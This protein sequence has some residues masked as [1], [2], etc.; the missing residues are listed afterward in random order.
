MNIYSIW[1][2]REHLLIWGKNGIQKILLLP[3]TGS[4]ELD[5]GVLARLNL[6]TRELKNLEKLFF[7]SRVA[8]GRRLNM[9]NEF[10]PNQRPRILQLSATETPR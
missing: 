9:L 7:S 3:R 10:I 4:E 1:G 8:K 6:Q 2:K 5:Y